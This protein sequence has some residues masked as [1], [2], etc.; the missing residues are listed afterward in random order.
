M[1][2]RTRTT[3][4]RLLLAAL[5]VIVAGPFL[6]PGSA[7]AASLVQVTG[8]GTNPGNLGM[9]AYLPD[10]LPSGAPLVVALH[11]CTQSANDYFGHSG[12]PK[13]ADTYGFALVFAQTTSANNANS[14]F[15]WFQSGDYTRGQG[16]AL[17]IKQ[18]VDYAKSHYGSDPGRV[19]VTGLSAGGAMTAVMLA[20]YPDVFAGGAIDSG[21]PAGCA[22]DLSSGLTC[23]YSAVSKTP[24][25]W[26]D[27]VR[28]AS[29]GWGGPWP[30]VAIWHGT[31]DY[32]VN[33]ANATESRDQWT[34]VW[35]IGQTPSS[36][37]SLPGGTT[38]ETYGG[39]GEPAVARFT[40]SGMAHGLA[41]DPGSAADQCGTTGTYYLDYICSS[42]YT[43]RFWGLDGSSGGGG[44][45]LPA[46]SGVSV[47]AT[48]DSSVSLSW[49]AVSGAASYTVYRNGSSVGSTASTSYTDTGLAPGTT[50]GYT[51]AGVD[52]DGATGATS[53]PVEAT[54]TGATH[55]C[56]T[57]NNYNQVAAGRA[58][59]NLGTVYANGSNQNMGLYNVY[60]THTLEETSPGY[61]VIADNGC[62]A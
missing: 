13:F 59:Q 42:Y 29:G 50:Y 55:R 30:R 33:P 28:S 23:E 25:Q 14:C 32:T 17:S 9:Y 2:T 57:D 39:G 8:F 24:R 58:H 1:P 40:I 51:V 31:G 60:A 22:T 20:D 15:N 4:L 38:E 5:L 47:T 52:S 21:I 6:A 36:T 10:T 43:A 34:D 48:T 41:V 56:Y 35:G 53:S 3:R 49:S 54:T 18:M 16:E 26:G 37:S 11:G 45:S 19:Y 46:P 61:F 62:P 7:A 27:L 12:W 44:G